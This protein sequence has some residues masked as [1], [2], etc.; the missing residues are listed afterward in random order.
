[1]TDRPDRN[2][3]PPAAVEDLRRR[4]AECAVLPPDHPMRLEVVSEV[5][6]A[7]RWAENEWVGLVAGDERLRL[8]LMRVQPPVALEQRLKNLLE[9]PEA[10]DRGRWSIGRGTQRALIVLAAMV[11]LAATL[12]LGFGWLTPAG[13]EDRF[14]DFS[15]AAVEHQLMHRPMIVETSNP[16]ELQRLLMGTVAFPFHVPDLRP[17]GYTLIG[18]RPCH[19]NG[20]DVI[21]S[22]WM[23]DGKVYSLYIFCPPDF[24]L[25]DRFDRRTLTAPI[26]RSSQSLQIVLW[27]DDHCGFA[28]MPKVP[29]AS[30]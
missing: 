14:E 5:L 7:G 28:L 29:P 27:S 13:A 24:Q 20:R 26:G 9:S 8:D 4:M 2:I 23:R 16:M 17:Q 10:F 12:W 15:I 30:V 3:M 11:L 25:P 21:Q 6:A 19:I 22:H 1:M 18:A